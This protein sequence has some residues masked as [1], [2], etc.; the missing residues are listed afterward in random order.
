[1][2]NSLRKHCVQVRGPLRRAAYRLL[3]GHHGDLLPHLIGGL[4]AARK[5]RA[6]CETQQ[7]MV[8]VYSCLPA[9]VAAALAWARPCWRGEMSPDCTTSTTS[10]Q[11]AACRLI[12]RTTTWS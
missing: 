7:H 10:F 4:R 6:R 8:A 2:K 11:T 5:R 12:T 9:P 3:G 1:M